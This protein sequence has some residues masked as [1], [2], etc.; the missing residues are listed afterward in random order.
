MEID[1]FISYE[2][3]S[4]AIA[5]NICAI[6][7]RYKIRCWY[8]PRDV[9]GDYATSIVEAIDKAKIFVVVLDG[10][11]SN[12]VH[13]L[14]EVEIA[15]K[16][17]IDGDSKIAIMPFRVNTD[18][19]SKAMEY[20]IKRM[21][22]ID[23]SSKDLDVAILELKNKIESII[24]VKNEEEEIKETSR[25]ENHYFNA[26]DEKEFKRLSIQQ[27][28]V[29]NFDNEVYLKAIEQY[30]C[31]DVLDVGSNNGDLIIDR[32]GNSEKLNTLIGIEFDKD[33]VAIAN[34]KYKKSN[35]EF[36]QGDA[37]SEQLENVLEDACTIHH[38][39]KFNVI[40]I[41]MLILHLKNP[42]KMLKIIRKF[43]SSDGTLIIK[44]IDDGLNL[45]YPDPDKI[46]KKTID[47]C[48]M[49]ELSGYRHSGRQ[50]YSF[51]KKAGF[52]KINLVKT[53]LSTINMDY[54]QK[55][56]LFNTYFSFILDDIRILKGKYPEDKSYADAYRF[57][58]SVYEKLE[59]D[60]QS[61]EFFFSLGFMLFT[62]SK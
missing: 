28:L 36:Y 58:D 2:H 5:D 47:I 18:E 10:N 12:S 27:K 61:E 29:K 40:N 31:L 7:E 39:E 54:E 55:E 43:L 38:V 34:N 22:W 25:V 15:Y 57:L 14:N 16:R 50:I 46:F 24:G 1:V 53:G 3:T 60:F 41:S 17:I 48:S 62:A 49:S 21:H 37:E 20:Y 59:E 19:L 44:D 23:A 33:T 6:L 30:D 9:I 13:V 35:I 11:S 45:A 8:A 56:A 32:L 42:Y 26:E 4:K 51:L 52:K